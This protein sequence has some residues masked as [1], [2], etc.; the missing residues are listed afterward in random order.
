MTGALHVKLLVDDCQ[1][2]WHTMK[3]VKDAMSYFNDILFFFDKSNKHCSFFSSDF[4]ISTVIQESWADFY[5]LSTLFFC[6][7][8]LSTPTL[9]ADAKKNGLQSFAHPF[10]TMPWQLERKTDH[11]QSY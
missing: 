9:S 5:W 8:M 4:S 11:C 7:T 2:L 10:P 3:A 6:L 1:L